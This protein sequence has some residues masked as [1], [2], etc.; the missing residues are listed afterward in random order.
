MPSD[1]PEWAARLDA[2]RPRLRA[3]AQLHLHAGLRR[4]V[5]PSD[6]VQQTLLK[7][8]ANAADFRG[9]ADAELAAWLRRILANTLAD[10]ARVFLGKQRDVTRERSLEV[11]VEDSSVWLDRVADSGGQTERL[12]R[13]LEAL[14]ELPEDQRRAV[15]L[16]HL[17]G[18]AVATVAARMARTEAAIAGLLRRAL[19]S[20]RATLTVGE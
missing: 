14:A 19:R 15:E 17:E 11:A 3:L 18:L 9:T 2:H 4:K 16:H 8:C 1:A 12:Q 10:A 13:L 6:I 20:L 5:D 7:A